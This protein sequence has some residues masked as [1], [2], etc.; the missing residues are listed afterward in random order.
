MNISMNPEVLFYVLNCRNNTICGIMFKFRIFVSR[1]GFSIIMMT[2]SQIKNFAKR[3]L[4]G[5]LLSAIGAMML[6]FICFSLWASVFLTVVLVGIVGPV[7]G[8]LQLI[9]ISS[10]PDLRLIFFVILGVVIAAL[11]FLGLYLSVGLMLG[12]QRFYLEMVKGKQVRAFDIFKGFSDNVHLKHY[13]G[14][15]MILYLV[16]FILMIPVSLVGMKSGYKSMDYELTKHITSF[17]SFIITLFLGLSTYASA[18]NRNMKALDAIKV[19]FHLMRARKFK[20]VIFE[21]SFILWFLL[22]AITCGI[23]AFWVIP[24]F[25]ASYSIFYLSAYGEDYR[26]RTEE[27]EPKDSYVRGDAVPEESREAAES[28]DD[29]F[30]AYEQWKKEHGIGIDNPDPFHDRYTD[31]DNSTKEEN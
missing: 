25:Y 13:L 8:R 5:N 10:N 12:T 29:G 7:T 2:I 14:V 31:P 26:N 18:D 19:S 15:V 16:E 9:N 20:L 11:V 21:L 28:H 6:S 24:Y 22:M 27:S 3:Q 30:S 23:A 17:L 4:K 1:G